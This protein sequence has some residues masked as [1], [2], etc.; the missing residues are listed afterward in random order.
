LYKHKQTENEDNEIE[1]KYLL[2][3]LESSATIVRLAKR[4]M[5]CVRFLAKAGIFL[6]ATMSIPVLGPGHPN[7]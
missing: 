4:F 2:K 3:S 1:L 6:F 7:Q 5:T